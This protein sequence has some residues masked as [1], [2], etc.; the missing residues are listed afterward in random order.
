MSSNLIEGTKTMEMWQSGRLRQ[1]VNLFLTARWFESIRLHQFVEV[2]SSGLLNHS[3]SR[4]F[5]R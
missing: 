4:E 1:T 3:W 5:N 2:D